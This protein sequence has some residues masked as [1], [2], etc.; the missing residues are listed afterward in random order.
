MLSFMLSACLFA[1]P[2]QSVS[3]AEIIPLA[4]LKEQ[5]IAL[6]N[7]VRGRVLASFVKKGMSQEQVVS[8]LGNCKLRM[9]LGLATTEAYCD[10]GVSVTYMDERFK[11]AGR[12]ECRSV[13]VN[14]STAPLIDFPAWLLSIRPQRPSV[15]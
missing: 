14:V 11:V 1:S 4:D 12:E 10:L 7:R 5:V 2:S 6:G 15:P 8:L 3:L 13:V 9:I